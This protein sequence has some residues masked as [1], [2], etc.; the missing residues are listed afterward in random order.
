MRK[1]I[2]ESTIYITG[3]A[4]FRD[5]TYLVA[6]DRGLESRGVAHSRFIAF[7]QGKFAHMGDRNWTGVA[8]CV[9]KKPAEKMVAVGEDG[10]VF[11]YV[12]GKAAD[13]VIEPR[14]VALRGIGVVDGF[15]IACGMKRQVFRRV[16]ENSWAAMHAPSPK[17]GENAGFEDICGF[18]LT[19]VYAVGWNGEIWQWDGVRWIDRPSPT[20]LILTGVC[21]GTDGNVYAC[22]QNGTLVA[23]RNDAW[24]LISQENITEDFWD[25]CWFND[26]L[27]VSSMTMVF[28][29]TSGELLPVDFGVGMP[30]TFGRLTEADG[31]LWSIGSADVFSFNG[32][33][34]TR[35]D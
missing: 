12:G 35:I 28:A 3:S 21:C 23:G 15:S 16:G 29:F 7:Y 20:N 22:G 13:E 10:D 5:L 30:A 11:T 14:P 32:T 9:A 2:S 1:R 4:R 31:A 19:E 26:R 33:T 6:R 25:V 34:W 18:S 24:E 8:T 17:S 27:Y